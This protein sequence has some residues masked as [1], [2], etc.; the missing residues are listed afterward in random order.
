MTNEPITI[1]LLAGLE[2]T[3]SGAGLNPKEREE[4][5]ASLRKTAHEL[6]QLQRYDLGERLAG[7][8]TE[9]L[10]KPV[11]DVLAEVWK[12]RKEMQ[13]AAAK[14]KDGRDVEA[15]VE[16]VDHTV[17]WD[18]HPSVKLELN[19]ASVGTLRF[20]VA[21]SFKL[22]GVQI[23]IKNACVTSIK[24]GTLTSTVDM[25]Y[26]GLPLMTPRKKKIDLPGELALPYGGLNLAPDLDFGHPRE[27]MAQQ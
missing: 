7:F 4:L 14:G 27:E 8:L 3:T 9:S 2:S 19:G 22:E 1:S 10:R 11:A 17:K 12:Q 26:K 5:V 21:V 24:A 25:K 16:L 20:D 13:D 6:S 23:L 18:L 15:D